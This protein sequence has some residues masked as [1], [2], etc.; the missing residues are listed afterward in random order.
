MHVSIITGVGGVTNFLRLDLLEHFMTFIKMK[1][2]RN[3]NFL[4][5]SSSDLRLCEGFFD[6]VCCEPPDPVGDDFSR[7]QEWRVFANIFH[8]VPMFEREG[9]GDYLELC[10]ALTRKLKLL[11]GRFL[12]GCH[13]RKSRD[14]QKKKTKKTKKQ[15]DRHGWGD[16][17]ERVVSQFAALVIY[18]C[19]N[20]EFRPIFL[21][22]HTCL[23]DHWTTQNKGTTNAKW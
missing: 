14:F 5:Q 6:I 4:F 15:T 17:R 13:V 2:R 18:P 19:L 7:Q 22:I 1:G 11:C 23:S 3:Y 21:N 16:F 8:L 10:I 20:L 12:V 9:L